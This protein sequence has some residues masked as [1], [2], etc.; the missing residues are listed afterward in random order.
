MSNWISVKDRLPTVCD[1]YLVTDGNFYAMAM[2][3]L[4]GV[5]DID[6]DF[7]VLI[8]DRVTHWMPLPELPNP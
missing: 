5:W 6:D 4:S 8:N 7:S 2:F 1:D 3:N